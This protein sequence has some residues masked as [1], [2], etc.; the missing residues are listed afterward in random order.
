MR[1]FIAT[2]LEYAVKKAKENYK[3]LKLSGTNELL[4]YANDVNLLGYN[5]AAIKR[6]HGP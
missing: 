4:V 1:Y 5:I 3:G 2:T 6:A